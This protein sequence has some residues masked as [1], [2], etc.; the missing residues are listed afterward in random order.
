MRTHCIVLYYMTS[1]TPAVSFITHALL[2]TMFNA[3]KVLHFVE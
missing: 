3:N 1:D 2:T